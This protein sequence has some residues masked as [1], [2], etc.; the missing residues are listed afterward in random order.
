VHVETNALRCDKCSGA[1]CDACDDCGWWN[2]RWTFPVTLTAGDPNNYHGYFII[3]PGQG[4]PDY[5]TGER[6]NLG[7]V[8]IAPMER[9]ECNDVVGIFYLP[10]SIYHDGGK[11]CFR[12]PV[13]FRCVHCN[14]QGC[15]AG[16]P[17]GCENRGYV[18]GTKNGN[19]DLA[20]LDERKRGISSVDGTR[21]LGQGHDARS[22]GPAGNFVVE[23]RLADGQSRNQILM[24]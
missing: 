7:I 10:P 18:L 20:A 4:G 23:F 14:G 11:H 22:G 21:I 5:Y 15:N 9:D 13:W 19:L 12:Y 1:G 24:S 8:L 17:G 6:G 3:W 16:G 2:D